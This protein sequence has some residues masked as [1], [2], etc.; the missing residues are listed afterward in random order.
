MANK[1][2]FGKV[3][4]GTTSVAEGVKAVAGAVG[5]LG[6]GSAAAGGKVGV[7]TVNAGA[8]VIGGAL[9]LAGKFMKKFPVV[10][11][12]V[13]TYAALKGIQ[14]L[15]HR[16]QDKVALQNQQ[17]VEF[18]PAPRVQPG[19]TDDMVREINDATYAADHQRGGQS[20][21]ADRVRP[22]G[23]VQQGNW[24]DSVS[25]NGQSGDISR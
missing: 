23:S 3:V 4:Q 13:G 24:R 18:A 21:F 16:H 12:L 17:A 19:V 2:D 9:N 14:K 20:Q 6:K 7:G 11:L 22:Q 10:S 8:G 1:P 5:K 25:R 15:V